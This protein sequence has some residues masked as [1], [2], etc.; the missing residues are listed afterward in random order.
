[1][2]WLLTRPVVWPVKTAGYSVQAG[3]KTGRLVGYRRLTVFGLGVLVG[4]L[5][6]PGPGAE[7]RA[8]LK[9]RFGPQEP[10]PLPEHTAGPYPAAVPDP[11]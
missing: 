6:A 10:I 3:Y 8:K 11:A 1:M 4:M 9:E 5:F 7:L 2:I